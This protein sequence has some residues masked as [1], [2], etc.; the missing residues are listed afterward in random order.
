MDKVSSFAWFLCHS[1]ATCYDCSTDLLVW[2]RF[3]S[4]E[5]RASWNRQKCPEIYWKIGPGILLLAPGSPV[6]SLSSFHIR[7]LLQAILVL[8]L[9]WSLLKLVCGDFSVCVNAITVICHVWCML[10]LAVGV[11]LKEAL[12]PEFKLYQQ[13]VVA[14]AKAL[15]TALQNRGFT[16]VSGRLNYLNT[17]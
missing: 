13:Q 15:C 11:A 8:S 9:V 2:L 3:V 6:L 17:M 4:T 12:S 10:I 7:T 1:C 16:V 14:N 5:K